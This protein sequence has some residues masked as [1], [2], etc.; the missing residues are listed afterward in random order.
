MRKHWLA[1]LWWAGR[2]LAAPPEEE[3]DALSRI[4][5]AILAAPAA[6]ATPAAAPAAT[7]AAQGP[8]ARLEWWLQAYRWRTVAL[9]AADAAQPDW[10]LRLAVDVRH[11]TALAPGLRF[12]FSD[13]L[14]LARQ[15]QERLGSASVRNTLRELYLSWEA[16]PETF[17]DAG[18]INLRNGVAGGFNPTD[19]LRANSVVV[20]TSEDPGA[21]RQNRLG[22]AMLRLQ[23]V[24]PRGALTALYAPRLTRK[25]SDSDHPLSLALQRTNADA[26]WLVKGSYR[27]ADQLSPEVMAFDTGDAVL[28]GANL[29]WLMGDATVGHAE[30]AG[31]AR[32]SL[33]ARATGAADSAAAFRQALAAGLTYTTP[34]RQTLTLEYQFN[35]AGLSRSAWRSLRAEA[36]RRGAGAAHYGTLRRHAQEQQEPLTRSAWFARLAWPEAFGVS[37]LEL[38]ALARGNPFDRSRMAQ[39]EASYHASAHLSL[40]ANWALYRGAPDSEYGTL[41]RSDALSLRLSYFF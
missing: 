26:R 29:T 33:L 9:P 4:P 36:P 40:T 3:E 20:R 18:R 8:Q 14:D 15:Q 16:A 37:E 6:A 30:W 5:Q 13:R 39:L 27:I 2:C 22:T 32:R 21:L 19:F 25:R 38:G 35:G 11:E 31:G 34:W 23:A 28:A 24:G 41:R 1:V 17:L 7:L 12:A 10:G